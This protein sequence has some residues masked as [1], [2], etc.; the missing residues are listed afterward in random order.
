MTTYEIGVFKEPFGVHF[1]A[2]TTYGQGVDA[3]I[4]DGTFFRAKIQYMYHR[5]T[6]GGTVLEGS[7]DRVAYTVLSSERPYIL[8][9]GHINFV[10]GSDCS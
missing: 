3:S 6:A 1:E 4:W 7:V 9:D 5:S 10:Y 2:S 8:Q